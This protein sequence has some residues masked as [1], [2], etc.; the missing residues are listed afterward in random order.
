[1]LKGPQ[2]VQ[3]NCKTC[4]EAWGKEERLLGASAFVPFL[5]I[6]SA[7]M[8]APILALKGTSGSEGLGGVTGPPG[9]SVFSW[10]MWPFSCQGP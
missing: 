6:S 2:E 7:S 1:M 9:V 8:Y 3:F 10:P 4:V 5:A